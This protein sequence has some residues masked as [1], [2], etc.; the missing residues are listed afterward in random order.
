MLQ[1][2]SEGQSIKHVCADQH[3]FFTPQLLEEDLTRTKEDPV[4]IVNVAALLRPDCCEWRTVWH[5]RHV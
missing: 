2:S 5:L 4:H 1:E 3:C